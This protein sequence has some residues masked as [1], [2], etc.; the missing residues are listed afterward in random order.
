MLIF[1]LYGFAFLVDIY[2]HIL[3][4]NPCWIAFQLYIVKFLRYRKL[5]PAITCSCF[6]PLLYEKLFYITSVTLRFKV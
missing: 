2:I 4:R 3:K 6:V 5:F 1:F